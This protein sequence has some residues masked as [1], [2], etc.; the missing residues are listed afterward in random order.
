MDKQKEIERMARTGCP[1]KFNLEHFKTCEE[2][3]T[4][5]GSGRHGKCDVIKGS[6]TLVEAG[7]GDIQQAIKEFTKNKVTPLINELVELLFD[8][9]KSNCQV[10]NCEK[11]DNIPCGCSICIEENKQ[12]WKNKLDRLLR[13]FLIYGT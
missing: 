4:A 11:S 8:E 1:H 5:C 7:F 10:V 9:N 13:E 2:C 3:L 6:T 12:L